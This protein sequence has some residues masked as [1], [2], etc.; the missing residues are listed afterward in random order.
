MSA[1]AKALRTPYRTSSSGNISVS[2]GL[3]CSP[4]WK[5]YA[6]EILAEPFGNLEMPWPKR[7]QYACRQK[8]SEPQEKKGRCLWFEEAIC[9]E[10][11]CTRQ[12]S[13]VGGFG[14]DA[15]GNPYL[16]TANGNGCY[17]MSAWERPSKCRMPMTR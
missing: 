13:A 5:V 2:A 12:E 10:V 17:A 7:I 11:T 14:T 9:N 16:N 1:A 4:T 6:G 8:Q 3:I 15:T